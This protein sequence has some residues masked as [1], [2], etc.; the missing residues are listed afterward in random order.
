[1]NYQAAIFDMDGLLLDTERVCQQ[2]FRD[3]CDFLSL[4]FMEDVYLGIIGCN[5]QGIE[6]ILTAGYGHL[7]A[8]EPLRKE[9]MSRYNPIVQTQ[10]IPVKQGVLELLTW[11][12]DNHIPI[13]LATSTHRELAINKL[14]LAGLYD[15]FEHLSTGCEVKHG[16][17]HPEIF[18]LAAKRLN[19]EPEL[20]L[21]FEDSNNGVRSAVAANMQVFQIPDLVSP[22]EEVTA[23]GHIIKDSMQEVQQY[24]IKHGSQSQNKAF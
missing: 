10:A 14:T 16:K 11:L 17:P 1:M 7:I 4:P 15:F 6:K 9:W 2:A 20:C 22:C 24:I 12:K 19:V 13:A 3:A 23:L 8:Y 5:A 21:A 18:L